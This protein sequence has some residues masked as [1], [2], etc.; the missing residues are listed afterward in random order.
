LTA[1]AYSLHAL[2]VADSAVSTTKIQD[3]AVTLEKINA[4]G[5]APGQVLAVTPEGAV[6]WRSLSS[7]DSDPKAE[8]SGKVGSIAVD[9]PLPVDQSWNTPGPVF[10]LT[11]T[12]TG[13]GVSG[14]TLSST[15]TG[16]RGEARTTTGANMGVL[17]SATS[18]NGIGVLG[19]HSSNTGIDPGVH[20]KPFQLLPMQLV[21]RHCAPHCARQ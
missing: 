12:G 16:V 20:G 10:R 14:I 11:N 6:A 21:S 13:D 7:A 18:T 9:I 4:A 2:S 1:A 5:A 3:K 19:R 8:N 17:G 15:G